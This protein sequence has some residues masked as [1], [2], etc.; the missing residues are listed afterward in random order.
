MARLVDVDN[1]IDGYFWTSSFTEFTTYVQSYVEQHNCSFML[2]VHAS[3]IFI[4]DDEERE[5]H[6]PPSSPVLVDPDTPVLSDIIENIFED[7]HRIENYEALEGS[8]W[9]IVP[10]TF[11]YWFKITPC[12]PNNNANDN[13]RNTSTPPE[14]SQHDDPDDPP[15]DPAGE[16]VYDTFLLALAEYHTGNRHRFSR[17][18]IYPYLVDWLQGEQIQIDTFGADRINPSNVAEWHE[19]MY[20]FNIRIFSEHGNILYC[21][22]MEDNDDFIDLL[23]KYRKFKLITN[24]WG[25]LVEKSERIFCMLCKKFHRSAGACIQ[26]INA[27]KTEQISVPE[28]PEGKHAFVIYADFESVVRSNDDHECSGYGYVVINKQ[29][30]KIEEMYENVLL[31]PN[32]V[33]SFLKNIFEC[34]YTWATKDI[35]NYELSDHICHICGDIVEGNHIIGK[36]F[37]NGELGKHHPECWQ[38]PKNRAICYFHNFRGYDSHYVLRG[39]MKKYSVEFIR[40]KSF[41][42]FDII[43]AKLDEIYI[44]FKDTFNYLSTSLAKL[45]EQVETWQYTPEKDRN[46]KGTFPYKWFDDKEKLKEK[47]LPPADRWFNDLTNVNVDPQSAIDIWNR[48]K[49]NVFSQFHDYYMITDV[50]QLADIFEEFRNTCIGV[51]KLDPVYFQGAPGYTWQLSLMKQAEKMKV[52]MDKDIYIDITANI[53]GGIAQ[54]MHRYM[55][56]ENKPDESILYLDVNSLYSKCMTYKLPTKFICKL[57]KLPQDWAEIWCCQGEKTALICVDL[58]YPDHLH[59]LHRA[60]PLA[61]HKYNGRLCTTFLRKEKYLCHA[62]ALLFYISNG[63][64]IETFHYAYV[65]NQDYVLRDYVNNNII[66]RRKTKSLPLQSLYKTLNNSLYGKTCENKFKYR[67]F[68]VCDEE[69]SP[70]GRRNAY[71]STATNWLPIEDKI[72]TEQKINQVTLDKPIQVGFAILEFAKLEMYRFLFLIQSKFKEDVTPLYTDT[73]SL[74]LHFKHPNPQNILYEDPEIRKLLDFDKVPDHW[75]VRTPNTHK[76]SG[77]WSLESFEKIIEFIGLRAKTYCYRTADK[78]VLKNKGVTASA[79]ELHTKDKLTMDHY[80]E[81]LLQNKEF[82]VTQVTIG[83]KKHQIKTKRQLK[84]AITNADEKRQVLSDKI[85]TLPFGYQ[86]ERFAEYSIHNPDLL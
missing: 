54:V 4:K 49:F 10:D 15:S 61:P 79:V 85:T 40:G 5:L 78:T 84:L 17:R 27:S 64:L 7:L 14:D 11:T 16:R 26:H 83:S 8:G 20:R 24:L 65:F 63:L 73:D 43:S 81:V 76:E 42:K 68:M 36:N 6:M 72:L 55:N 60:Y 25:L 74:M 9:S 53:R 59:D 38:D 28:F 50:F 31:Q 30:E 22:K 13:S 41:E 3:A 2:C 19:Q 32:I 69:Q 34:A 75:T 52:I 56:I 46:S 71:L 37:I 66:E 57:D 45:V 1:V 18:R 82:Y 39:L 12:Q 35:D 67:K 44:T 51:S 62:E 47:Q 58:V 86:G 70:H 29:G 80:R 48:E 77:L 21:R 23:W 33:D